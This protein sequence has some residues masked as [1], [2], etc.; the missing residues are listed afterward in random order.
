MI[1][2]NQ[3]NNHRGNHND[4]R[5]N[6]PLSQVETKIIPT[7]VMEVMIST[8]SILL[9]ATRGEIVEAIIIIAS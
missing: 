5:V 6:P 3:G 1:G 9:V 7:S 2:G 4:R 8:I